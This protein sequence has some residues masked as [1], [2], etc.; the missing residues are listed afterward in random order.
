VLGDASKARERLGWKPRHSLQGLVRD[1]VA[2][3]L[4]EAEK[5]TDLKNGGYQVMNFHE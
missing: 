5:D 4:R 1:M 2:H 3:D